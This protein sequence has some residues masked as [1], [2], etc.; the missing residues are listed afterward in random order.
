MASNEWE[1]VGLP[2]CIERCETGGHPDSSG[3]GIEF[4]DHHAVLSGDNVRPDDRW[5]LVAKPFHPA[6]RE[7]AFRF[8][9]VKVSCDPG[10]LEAAYAV[11]IETV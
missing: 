2:L 1:I 6:V 4:G 5:K 8:A 11:R 3:D 9:L 10:W 7:Q